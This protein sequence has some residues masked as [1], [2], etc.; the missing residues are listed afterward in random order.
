MSKRSMTELNSPYDICYLVSAAKK[1]AVFLVLKLIVCVAVFALAAIL[2]VLYG[3]NILFLVPSMV[4]ALVSAGCF[5]KLLRAINLS[6]YKCSCGE[7]VDVLKEIKT[8]DTQSIGGINPFGTRQYD[9]YKKNETRLTVFV[10]EGEN[11][12]SYYLK[13]V[14]EKHLKYYESSGDVIHIWGTRFPVKLEIGNEEWLCPVCGEFNS[15]GE[16]ECVMCKS[17]VIK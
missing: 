6:D 1:K 15:S 16:K 2:I 5:G 14:S 8:V 17:R 11:V 4:A 9:S 12:N 7:V 3:S 10:K 13:G